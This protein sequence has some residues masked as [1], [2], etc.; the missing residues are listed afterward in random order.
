MYEERYYI[1]ETDV[2]QVNNKDELNKSH[3]GFFIV[4]F[5]QI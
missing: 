2:F 3:F 5:E 1:C 4:N